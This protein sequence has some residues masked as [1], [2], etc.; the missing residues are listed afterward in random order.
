MHA[1]LL[2]AAL[3]LLLG[4]QAVACRSALYNTT[5]SRVEAKL[6]VHIFS[7]THNEPGW[8]HSYAQYHRTLDLDGHVIG[9]VEAILDT[10]VSSLVD[11]PDMTFV[12]ADLA[13]FV[14]WWQ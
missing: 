3:T 8:L 12:Y 4:P 6:N 13:F 14:K 9:G 1:L 7:H 5:A 11:N 2:V 10:A